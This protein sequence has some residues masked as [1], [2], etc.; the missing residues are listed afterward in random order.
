MIFIFIL[1][2]FI[3]GIDHSFVGF[4]DYSPRGLT[5]SVFILVLWTIIWYGTD[6][7]HH[8]EEI[9]SRP[10]LI[11][12]NIALGSSLAFISNVLYMLGDVHIFGNVE[13]W[14][15]SPY[16][17][18]VH[19]FAL[20]F[21]YLLCHS[22]DINVESNIKVKEEQLKNVRLEKEKLLNQFV[23]LKAQI[24]PHF[25]FN[26]LSV[27]E[28]L[29][30]Q[31]TTLASNFVVKLSKTMRYI[32]DKNETFLI[33]L[34]DEISVVKDYVYLLEIRF[35]NSLQLTWDINEAVSENTFIP[36][37][38]MQGLVENAVK[39]NKLTH[40]NPLAIKISVQKDYISVSNN[41]NPKQ[42]TE[43]R[44]GTGLKNISERYEFICGKEVL[45]SKNETEFKVQLPIIE[46]DTSDEFNRSF[47]Q[48][49]KREYY[50]FTTQPK[51]KK[52]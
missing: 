51:K 37:I 28:S 11:V 5:F 38:A 31:D 20:I 46:Q 3:K 4:W 26:S 52:S 32:T 19:T 39:H 22:I 49:E 8:W 7:I 10:V 9:Y 2:F 25:L 36:P 42:V 43:Q 34:K 50:Y 47:T 14:A 21:G 15:D 1:H 27:L 16:F 33:P 18:P 24:E 45:V 44:E 12:I 6:L 17:N 23:K 48:E 40:S 41:Y 29:I 13:Y 35:Q 30:H